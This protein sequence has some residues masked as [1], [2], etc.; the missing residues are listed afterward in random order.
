MPEVEYAVMFKD[1]TIHRGPVDDEAW[2][3]EWINGFV[4]DG[5]KPDVFY[6]VKRVVGDWE[7]LVSEELK[8][9]EDWA[10]DYPYEIRDPDGWDRVN[11]T[12]SW[13]EL[14]S[15]K[16]FIRRAGMSTVSMKKVA[17]G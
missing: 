5:G 16:E 17:N 14:I 8:S 4:E 7:R 11:F 13:D 2:V 12:E 10:K 1:N 3:D 6:K 9:S 15:Y